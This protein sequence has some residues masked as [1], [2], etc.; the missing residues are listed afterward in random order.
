MRLVADVRRD[1]DHQSRPW[2]FCHL[3]R[4]RSVADRRPDRNIAILRPWCRDSADGAARL[5]AAAMGAGTQPAGRA[6]G[7]FARD[8]RARHRHRELAVRRL[9]RGHT[10]AGARDWRS[11]IRQL[12]AHRTDLC[13]LSRRA[14][15]CRG[16]SVAG[17]TSIVPEMDRARPRHSR[18]RRRP[19]YRRIG[20]CEFTRRVRD[21]RR[22][23]G[24]NHGNRRNV[25][26]NA[27]HLRSL[28]RTGA[29]HLRVRGGRDRRRRLAMG[30]ADRRHHSWRRPERRR[31]NRAAWISAYRAY[32]FSPGFGRAFVH[33]GDRLAR[34]LQP[35]LRSPRKGRSL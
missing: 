31:T 32:R 8:V 16:R 19:R 15:F 13:R 14:G 29:A 35:H 11:R 3:G 23:C 2:R 33:V 4:V 17:R 20:R 28:F 26:G 27:C 18:H 34:G 9:R 22:Y 30:D 12:D 7:A 10:L 24:R 5:G 21:R 6:A 25:S 1:A